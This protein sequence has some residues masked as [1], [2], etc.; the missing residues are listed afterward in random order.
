M[1][2]TNKIAQAGRARRKK[3]KVGQHPSESGPA[4]V[5]ITE[6]SDNDILLG[7]GFPVRSREANRRFRELVWRH[8]PAY[9]ATGKHA[10]KDRIAREILDT[11]FGKGGRFV[12][13]IEAEDRRTFKIT[14][15][16]AEAWIVVSEEVAREKCKQALRD[17]VYPSPAAVKAGKRA[18]KEL[19]QKQKSTHEQS[20][21]EHIQLIPLASAGQTKAPTN[22]SPANGQNMQKTESIVVVP[23]RI[24]GKDQYFSPAL[25]DDDLS[26]RLKHPSHRKRY[27]LRL[28]QM[29]R[30]KEHSSHGSISSANT[31]AEASTIEVPKKSEGYSIVASALSQQDLDKANDDRSVSNVSCSSSAA[32]DSLDED[33]IDGKPRAL[34]KVQR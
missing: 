19:Q 9:E 34:K 13:R 28:R 12:R 31:P 29:K 2:A 21:M 5:Y 4:K 30:N 8:K 23:Q 7:R 26:F 3:R 17:S 1:S 14:E 18:P 24:L 16:V 15:S 32:S 22:C 10:V 20:Q 33:N 27:L 25:D 11:V 6:L